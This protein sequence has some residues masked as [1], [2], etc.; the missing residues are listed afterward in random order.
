MQGDQIP[1]RKIMTTPTILISFKPW[2]RIVSALFFLEKSEKD[3]KTQYA[4]SLCFSCHHKS[5]AKNTIAVENKGNLF[6]IKNHLNQNTN[7]AGR[8]SDS[9]IVIICVTPSNNFPLHPF[10]FSSTFVADVETTSCHRFTVQFIRSIVP[11]FHKLPR[12]R[13]WFT[14]PPT[15]NVGETFKTNSGLRQSIIVVLDDEPTLKSYDF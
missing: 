3:N 10:P 9:Q 15:T 11:R 6:E 8:D 5:F 13:D 7:H 2:I 1:E 4:I 14:S 12:P